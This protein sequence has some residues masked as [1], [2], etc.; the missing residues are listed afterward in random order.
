MTHP[1]RP[2]LNNGALAP[3]ASNVSNKRGIVAFGGNM[4]FLGGRRIASE[5]GERYG[6]WLTQMYGGTGDTDYVGYFFHRASELLSA[7]GSIG[8]IATNAIADGDNRRSIL[9]RLVA[10]TP[11]F[12]I[13]AADTGMPWPGN[14][15]VLVST[16]FLERGLPD[17][18][19]RPRLLDG[20]AVTAINSRLR[21]GDEWAE[22][23]P[24]AENSGLASSVASSVVAAS[25]SNETRHKPSWGSI[26]RKPM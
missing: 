23:A 4:P 26:Q 8:F 9:G 18:V 16:L 1:A 21:S 6:D 7:A 20:R 2:S 22:P 12:H 13:H 5:Q 24:L 11:A 17:R 25:F 14:A 19:T 15:Q 3:W 10:S